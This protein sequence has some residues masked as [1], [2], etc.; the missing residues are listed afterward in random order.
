M[1]VITIINDS[2]TAFRCHI[3]GWL[4]T[5]E[6]RE[7]WQYLVEGVVQYAFTSRPLTL[8]TISPAP[9]SI[10]FSLPESR[11]VRTSGVE[12]LVNKI[13]RASDELLASVADSEDFRRG[14]LWV[15][16]SVNHNEAQIRTII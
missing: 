6:E 15:A 4:Q 5:R 3:E 2:D 16:A 8:I 7:Q 12:Y 1:T 9:W 14:L 11:W 10:G 13:E